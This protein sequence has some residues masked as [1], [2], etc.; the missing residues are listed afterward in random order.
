MTYEPLSP[1]LT[2]PF[3]RELIPQRITPP[4]GTGHGPTAQ[5]LT[6]QPDEQVADVIDVEFGRSA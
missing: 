1:Y 2:D 5:W 3:L 4:P 6:H